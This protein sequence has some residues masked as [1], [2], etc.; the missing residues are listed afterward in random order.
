M[1]DTI[2]PVKLCSVHPFLSN[3]ATALSG[4]TYMA[5]HSQWV[6]HNILIEFTLQDHTRAYPHCFF[7]QIPVL[8]S[9]FYSYSP[10][11][12]T[13]YNQILEFIIA[14][15]PGLS[16]VQYSIWLYN[17]LTKEPADIEG[18]VGDY[19][20]LL[21]STCFIST[22]SAPIWWHTAKHECKG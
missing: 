8:D 1:W 7:R 21:P 19:W 6:H 2:C 3:I 15:S 20:S 12:P 4:G 10:I 17:F 9:Y 22:L 14:K 5:S 13:A 18:G 16:V 11:L